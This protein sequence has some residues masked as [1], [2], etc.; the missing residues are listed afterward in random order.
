MIE[1]EFIYF[2]E[3]ESF[4][5]RK[6][7]LIDVF[8]RRSGEVLG[9]IKWWGPWRQYVFAPLAQTVFNK[10]CMNTIIEK[11]DELMDERKKKETPN[12]SRG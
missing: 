6:T 3:R 11:I 1:N 5:P 9:S 10:S 8:N 2:E 4:A 12:V 7:H